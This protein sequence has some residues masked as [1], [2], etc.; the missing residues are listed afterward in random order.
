MSK[1]EKISNLLMIGGGSIIL[2]NFFIRNFF[3]TV[4]A[5]YIKLF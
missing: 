4:D 3:Y 5:G 2:G 1:L